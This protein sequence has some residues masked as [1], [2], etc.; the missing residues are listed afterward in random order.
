MSDRLP[1]MADG[2]LRALV[3]LLSEAGVPLNVV[4]SGSL[5]EV[6]AAHP[7]DQ[8]RTL[9]IV[10]L[11][12]TGDAPRSRVT[13]AYYMRPVERDAGGH[14][15]R[16]PPALLA[17]WDMQA[18][19]YDHFDWAVTDELAARAGMARADFEKEVRRRESELARIS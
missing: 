14:L 2:H 9:G 12:E 17:A 18:A 15:R 1:A 4:A 6:I 7:G 8:A 5:D 13:S 11:T 3:D 16:R 10:V 19:R